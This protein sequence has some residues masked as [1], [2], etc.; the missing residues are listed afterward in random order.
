MLPCALILSVPYYEICPFAQRLVARGAGDEPVGAGLGCAQVCIWHAVGTHRS[1]ADG[2]G[3][4]QAVPRS[5]TVQAAGWRANAVARRPG[6][7][8]PRRA[9]HA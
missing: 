4:R 2:C 1:G 5:G 9:V 8:R 7:S 3:R 6:R